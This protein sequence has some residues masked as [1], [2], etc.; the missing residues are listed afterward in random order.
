MTQIG[1]GGG[2]KS[3]LPGNSRWSHVEREIFGDSDPRSWD[4]VQLNLQKSTASLRLSKD[5]AFVHIYMEILH[6]CSPWLF[7]P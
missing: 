1:F 4:G 3:A 2:W 5:V 7:A 6:A